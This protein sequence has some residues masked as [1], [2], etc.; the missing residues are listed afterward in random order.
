MKYFVTVALPGAPPDL[1]G[2]LLVPAPR[3]L[4]TL[5][6]ADAWSRRNADSWRDSLLPNETYF[7][8][9]ILDEE[10]VPAR[11][12]EFPSG[13][14]AEPTTLDRKTLRRLRAGR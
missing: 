7:T 3:E 14:G 2:R 1:L 4:P 9:W 5:R 10:G 12:L 13:L 6:D 11:T 8:A